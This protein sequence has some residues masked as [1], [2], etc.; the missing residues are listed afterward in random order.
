MKIK[1][2]STSALKLSEYRKLAHRWKPDSSMVEMFLRLSKGQSKFRVYISPTRGRIA[3]KS[4][5][6][7][8]VE[9]AVVES[10]CTIDLLGYIRGYAQDKYGRQVKLGK[11]IKDLD[12]LQLINTDE[13]RKHDSILVSREDYILA[14]SH[15]AYDIIGA[16]TDRGWTSC[17]DLRGNYKESAPRR[18]QPELDN[19]SIIAYLVK[20]DDKNIEKPIARALAKR[21]RSSLGSERYI[22]DAVYPNKNELIIKTFQRWLD[23]NIN[24]TLTTVPND[25]TKFTLPPLQYKDGHSD[26]EEGGYA[27]QARG[28]KLENLFNGA[29]IYP[30]ESNLLRFI[31]KFHSNPAALRTIPK[32]DKFRT[33]LLAKVM[34]LRTSLWRAYGIQYKTKLSKIDIFI[35]NLLESMYDGKYPFRIALFLAAKGRSV[36]ALERSDEEY[37]RIFRYLDVEDAVDFP[38]NNSGL[39]RIQAGFETHYGRK[40]VNIHH[41]GYSEPLFRNLFNSIENKAEILTSYLKKTGEEI[42]GKFLIS[43]V[44]AW[45]ATV[46]WEKVYKALAISNSLQT[47]IFETI[48][49]FDR[50]D[51]Y[52]SD[53]PKEIMYANVILRDYDIRQHPT[54]MAEF[55]AAIEKAEKLLDSGSI[56]SVNAHYIHRVISEMNRDPNVNQRDL[57][58][59][60]QTVQRN[61]N[62]NRF[63]YSDVW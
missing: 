28:S 15:H 13:R 36:R 42:Q 22:V 12:V 48:G 27:N 37:E 6:P 11:V 45:I 34:K 2:I 35:A 44:D 8:A 30:S 4:K 61:P 24:K 5:L 17:T 7:K 26:N 18:I 23:S 16:S 41:Y 38:A 56:T 52:S 31:L 49:G 63:V 46:G 60:E 62:I 14:I 50:H 9:R 55:C 3:F 33:R 59:L 53:L 10:G 29:E 25:F 51:Y 54:D 58:L 39:V 20:T 57:A 40:I 1:L 32:N 47:A 43:N 19:R 21:F